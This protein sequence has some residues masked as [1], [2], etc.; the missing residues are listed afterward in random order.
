MLSIHDCEDRIS[1]VSRLITES[2][3]QALKIFVPVDLTIGS[4]GRTE[5]SYSGITRIFDS[6]EMETI[7]QECE[8][9]SIEMSGRVN[10][11]GDGSLS[12]TINLVDAQVVINDLDAMYAQD[13]DYIDGLVAQALRDESFRRVKVS[14]NRKRIQKMLDMSKELENKYRALRDSYKRKMKKAL[15]A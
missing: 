5:V 6:T 4:N 15:A 9:T 11:K 1:E 13:E 2:Q 10:F 12:F 3:M 7:F 14:G 8:I